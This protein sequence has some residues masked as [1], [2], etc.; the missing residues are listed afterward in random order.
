MES[1]KI[2]DIAVKPNR[3]DSLTDSQ[4]RDAACYLKSGVEHIQCVCAAGVFMPFIVFKT[5]FI[6]GVDSV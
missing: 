2:R 4:V 6:I 5:V 1:V 3:I